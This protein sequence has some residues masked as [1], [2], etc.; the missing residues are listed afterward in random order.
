MKKTKKRNRWIGYNK[1]LKHETNNAKH[2]VK[3]IISEN[4]EKTKEKVMDYVKNLI[5]AR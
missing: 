2:E 1:W 5:K 3:L 4:E